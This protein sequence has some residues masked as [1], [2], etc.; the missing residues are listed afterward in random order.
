MEWKLSDAR[1]AQYDN[2]LNA[3]QELELN[4][5][6]SMVRVNKLLKMR[7]EV[8]GVIKKWWDEVIKEMSLDPHRDYMI[9][10]DGIIQDVTKNKPEVKPADEIKLVE[11]A[12]A[13]TVGTQATELV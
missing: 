11:P 12:P 3:A 1:K 2:T 4:I 9:T 6:S 8:D 7:D 13:S 5:G 10:K